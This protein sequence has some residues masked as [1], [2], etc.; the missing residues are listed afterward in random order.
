MMADDITPYQQPQENATKEMIDELLKDYIYQ[1]GIFFM[2]ARSE[3]MKEQE[4]ANVSLTALIKLI[5]YLLELSKPDNVGLVE[6]INYIQ[7][8]VEEIGRQPYIDDNVVGALRRIC[9]RIDTG[10]LR[11]YMK[12]QPNIA[13]CVYRDTHSSQDDM[14]TKLD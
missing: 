5:H 6:E 3:D 8:V 9:D 1:K 7:D 14:S 2:N 13:P 4:S 10:P 12:T 11:P